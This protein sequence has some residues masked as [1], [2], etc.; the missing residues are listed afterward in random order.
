MAEEQLG[1]VEAL[2]ATAEAGAVRK[3]PG[4]TAEARSAWAVEAR[5]APRAGRA[6]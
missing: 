3:A 5:C 6:V 2:G 4:V 1:A